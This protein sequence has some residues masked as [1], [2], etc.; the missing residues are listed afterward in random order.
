MLHLK[1]CPDDLYD[2]IPLFVQRIENLLL[3]DYLFTMNYRLPDCCLA[4][5]SE[6]KLVARRETREGRERLKL[7]QLL[8]DI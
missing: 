3:T 2:A 1:T 8:N 4:G 6:E 7:T 5:R